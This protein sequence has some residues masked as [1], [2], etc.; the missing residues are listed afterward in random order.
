LKND[1]GEV[2][3]ASR[4]TLVRNEQGEPESII[5]I[6]SDLTEQKKLEQQFLRAQRL[7]SIGTLASGVA[8]DLNNVLVPI[9]MVA[10]L[11]R[12]EVSPE[13]REKFLSIVEASAQRGANIVR[14]VLTFARGAD[15]ERLLLQPIHLLEEISNII[16]GTFPKS[17]A[18]QVSYPEVVSTIEADP[19]Q[20]HQVL[21]NLAVNARDAMPQ[22]G[23]LALSASN[24]N[25]DEYY[26]RMAP[27]IEPGPY[28]VLQV[29]D[30]G[31]GIPREIIDKIFDP[32]FTTKDIGVGTGLGLST[33]LG[34]VK[35]HGG[36]VNVYSQPGET[37]FKIFLPAADT[38]Q[39]LEKP[40]PTGPI[41]AGQGE[42]ILIVDD[43][44]GIRE[45]ARALLE[46]HGY[47][48]VVAEDGP[49]ALATFARHPYDFKVVLTDFAI[50]II[51]GV[52]LI[53]A[54]RKINPDIKAILSTGREEGYQASDIQALG[55]QAC[56]TKPYTRDTLFETLHRVLTSE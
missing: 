46:K 15:G 37:I 53:R 11:L 29:R 28:V 33:V 25:L 26:A 48:P 5:S 20:L 44:P 40:G 32:F 50:P 54:M 35:S 12:G 39:E 19:T 21:L 3:T 43:E 7:E 22:G 30:S 24:M 31:T 27:G 9:L 1:G 45:I 36:F 51:D 34:I 6:N 17:I 2:V 13:E 14:Q 18:V 47:E 56:L 41:A 55:V 8:H 42:M 16:R 4:W 10:P 23:T 49:D 38:A 52:T